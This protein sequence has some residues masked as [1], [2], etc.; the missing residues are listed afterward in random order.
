VTSGAVSN[1]IRQFELLNNI[2]GFPRTEFE[3]A[4]ISPVQDGSNRESIESIRQLAPL[5]YQR[6]NRIVT[7]EDYKT[8][9]LEN[10]PN[11]K[12][13]NAWGGEDA[14][15]PDYGK[16]FVSVA[17]I[18]G[19][20]VSPTTRTSIEED[21][22]KKFSVVGITPTLVDPEYLLINLNTTVKYNKD[23]TTAKGS[24]ISSLVKAKITEF[25]D[26]QVFDYNQSFKYS[27]F[28]A[29][30]DSAQGAIVNSL[31]KVEIGKQF[32]PTGNT[33]GTYQLKFYNAIKPLS[34]YSVPYTN[35]GGN[36]VSL[37]DNGAGKLD[38]YING[39]LTKSGFGTVDYD[40][41]ICVLPGF[42][43]FMQT[44]APITILATPESS[45]IKMAFNNLAKLSTNNVVV[46]PEVRQ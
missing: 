8:A 6:Q 16:V 11:I 27:R 19:D 24:E 15:P 2:Q 28:L 38:Y 33:Q 1:G 45:D 14:I 18:F 32:T 9:I 31:A 13:I 7:V 36:Q 41:G 42:N 40:N 25:F 20:K 5:S 43:P 17:P 26:S 37:R 46:I 44:V 39:S 4:N 34:V 35:T 3:I 12:A 21:L 29:A 30:V 22:L 10:Y 23:R